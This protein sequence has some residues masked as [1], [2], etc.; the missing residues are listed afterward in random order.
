M[1]SE[2]LITTKWCRM[3]EGEN[4]LPIHIKFTRS[5]VLLAVVKILLKNS[6][7]LLAT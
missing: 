1:L 3:S 6:F 4:N 2:L 5:N 7:F